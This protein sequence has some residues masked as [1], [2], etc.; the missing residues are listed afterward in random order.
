M[1]GDDDDGRDMSVETR[2]IA[3]THPST[4]LGKFFVFPSLFCFIPFK[5][6]RHG[7]SSLLTPVSALPQTRGRNKHHP[8]TQSSRHSRA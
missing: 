1:I 3:T 8:P 4:T 5:K 6:P 2:E 7:I